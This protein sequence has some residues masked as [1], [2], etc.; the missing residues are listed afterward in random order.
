MLPLRQIAGGLWTFLGFMI[1]AAL[2]L[3]MR[4][5]PVGDG[6]RYLDTWTGKIHAAV[7]EDAPAAGDRAA[8]QR[9]EEVEV[10]E[11]IVERSR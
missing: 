1:V 8:N 4:Y 6:A 2:V 5:K 7:A 9:A 11:G 10:I 3:N